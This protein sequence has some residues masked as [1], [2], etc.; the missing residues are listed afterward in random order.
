MSEQLPLRGEYVV[1]EKGTRM[2]YHQH[3]A[4]QLTQVIKGTL[5]IQTEEGLRLIPPGRAVWITDGLPHSVY[6]SESSEIINCFI[7]ADQA[8]RVQAQCRTFTITPLLKALLEEVVDFSRPGRD[9]GDAETILSLIIHQLNLVNKRLD[10]FI[11]Y[12]QDRRLRSAI[13]MT[14]N[15]PEENYSLKHLAEGAGCSERTISRLFIKETGMNYLHWRDRYRVIC[16]VERLSRGF[17]V[18]QVALDLGYR[19]AN[20]FSTMFSRVMGMPPKRYMASIQF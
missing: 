1:H 3:P 7:L 6:Y 8:V 19:G 17:S 9:N 11:S 14:R 18:T 2:A 20:N 10:L 13:D 16:A 5:S 12:G 15:Y 4:A